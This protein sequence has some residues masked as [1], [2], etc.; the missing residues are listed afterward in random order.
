MPVQEPEFR[1]A[2]DQYLD[3][4]VRSRNRFGEITAIE[5]SVEGILGGRN[6]SIARKPIRYRFYINVTNIRSDQIPAVWILDPPDQYIR[7]VNIH[8]AQL[9]SDLGRSL[10]LVCWGENAII[11]ASAPIHARRLSQLLYLLK[12]LL[13]S[14]N[15]GSASR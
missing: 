12:S 10:P 15:F 2:Q 4:R 6:M 5:G 7:H 1:K 3:L 9:C 11:W 8:Q 13:N 14:Q